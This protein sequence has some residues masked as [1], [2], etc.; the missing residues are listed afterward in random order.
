MK[1]AVKAPLVWAVSLLGAEPDV[2]SAVF[3]PLCAGA[4][5]DV[6]RAVP[7]PP[8]S[9]VS[10]L[11][12]EPDVNNAT[13]SPLCMSLDG[14]AMCVVVFK[15]AVIKFLQFGFRCHNDCT[16]TVY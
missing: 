11:G 13:S 5:P 2:K 6:N 10:M 3:S 4:E 7:W 15:S 9:D 12:A 1:S 8:C 14:V 16:H